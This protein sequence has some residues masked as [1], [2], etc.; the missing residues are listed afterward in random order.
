MKVL[1]SA[2]PGSYLGGMEKTMAVA[3]TENGYVG[4]P[5]TYYVCSQY[6]ILSNPV[7]C[8]NVRGGNTKLHN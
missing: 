5:L 4:I 8:S 7:V 1:N 2:F 6:Y 3:P